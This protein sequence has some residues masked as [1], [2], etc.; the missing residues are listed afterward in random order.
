MAAYAQALFPRRRRR[1]APISPLLCSVSG[2]SHHRPAVLSSAPAGCA[3][4]SHASAT[5]HGD[6]MCPPAVCNGGK[7]VAPSWVPPAAEGGHG[8][9][10]EAGGGGGGVA[11]RGGGD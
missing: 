7:R 10:P 5:C 9:R 6:R 1:M 4:P 3:R 8:E 2:G 11:A